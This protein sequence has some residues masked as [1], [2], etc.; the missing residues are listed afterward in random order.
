[1]VKNY[2]IKVGR[3]FCDHCVADILSRKK[4]REIRISRKERRII[5]E[6]QELGT[7]SITIIFYTDET[8]DV[9]K[10]SNPAMISKKIFLRTQGDNLARSLRA[11]QADSARTICPKYVLP[12]R[13]CGMID[14]ERMNEI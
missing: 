4:F 11:A 12:S 13:T 9:E 1:M 10:C 8:L 7:F 14:K 6:L 5:I 3:C 2:Q